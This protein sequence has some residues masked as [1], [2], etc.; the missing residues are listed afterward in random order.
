MNTTWRG[1]PW[2][3]GALTTCLAASPLAAADGDLDPSFSNDGRTV[4]TWATATSAQAV[5]PAPNGGLFVAGELRGDPDRWTVARLTAA[6]GLDV[7]WAIVFEPFDFA[8]EGIAETNAVLDLRRDGA[9]R[10]L[11]AGE[12]RD[13]NGDR[14]PALARLTATGALDTTFDGD[15]RKVVTALPPGWQIDDVNDAVI[16]ADGSAVFVG[17]CADCPTAGSN[18][19]FVARLL[20][21]GNPDP[22]FSGD[23]WL[24]FS[25]NQIT[26]TDATSVAVD[27]AGS[28]TIAGLGTT[29][30][31]NP[32]LFVVRFTAGG[33]F[34]LTFGGGDGCATPLLD[35]LRQPTDLAVDPDTGGIVLALA[36]HGTANQ[37]GG[38]AAFTRTGAIDTAFADAGFLDL[39]LE[40]GARID[41]VAFESDGRIVAGGTIDATGTQTGG[42]FLLRTLADG[43]LDASFDGNGVKRVEFDRTPDAEDQAL[44]VTLSGGRLVAAGVARGE[45]LVNAF[46]L[47]RTRAALIFSDGFERGSAGAWPGD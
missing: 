37:E 14:L 31:G 40:E 39:D 20:P 29:F 13:G 17:N 1:H 46:A 10:L 23:G 42:F 34:D 18:A 2:L 41:A 27:A 24:A 30:V 12:V 38:L 4:L 28:I 5:T 36:G 43:T 16:L 25:H 19:A 22:G 32:A 7:P 11:L 44:A 26:A 8:A 6:G 33:A 21:N 35:P 9:E 15:G 45:A 47:L 3:M